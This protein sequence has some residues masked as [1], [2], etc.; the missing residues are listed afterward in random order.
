M[1]DFK[2]RQQLDRSLK[3]GERQVSDNPHEIDKWHVWRYEQAVKL[4]VPGWTVAD[5]GCG[6]GYG[7]R[8]LSAK[9]GKVLAFDDSQETI[10]FAKQNYGAEN[11]AYQCADITSLEQMESIDCAVAFEILEH[12]ERPQ[13]FMKMLSEKVRHTLVLSVPDISVDLEHSDFHYRHYTQAEVVDLFLKHGFNVL[14]V[15]T[16]MFTKGK[17]VYCVGEKQ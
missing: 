5:F 4:I 16:M 17:A 3:S 7:S 13:D 14:H 6:I 2:T 11:I 12:L 1:K 15:E 8:L 10:E 9:A